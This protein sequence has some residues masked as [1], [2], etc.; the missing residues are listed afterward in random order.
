MNKPQS[1][2]PVGTRRGDKICL[3]ILIER[4]G[5]SLSLKLRLA[6]RDVKFRV[7]RN[8]SSRK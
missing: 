6:G 5:G 4:S 8:G 7:V 1:D 3:I 2:V